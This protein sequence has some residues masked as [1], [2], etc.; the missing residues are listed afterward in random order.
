M[1][2]RFWISD[3]SR[4]GVGWAYTRTAHAVGLANVL[5]V[6]QETISHTLWLQI[7]AQTAEQ[8]WTCGEENRMAE[9]IDREAAVAAVKDV[10]GDLD[11]E[12]KSMMDFY[13]ALRK[14]QAANVAPVVRCRDCSHW[15]GIALGMRCKLYST[16]PNSWVCS[17]PD[18]FCSR[19][20]KKSDC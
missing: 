11:H 18:D 5:C 6:G 20:K 16:P 9:Y 4:T 10:I 14:I 12:C 13:C 15:S 7:S 2:N 19:G 3:R 17:K 8:K 1:E